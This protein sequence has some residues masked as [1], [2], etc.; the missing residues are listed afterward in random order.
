LSRG[1]VLKFDALNAKSV[2]DTDSLVTLKFS[3]PADFGRPGAILVDDKHDNEFFLKTI[4][5]EMPGTPV[6]FP[7]YSWISNSKLNGN[8]PRVFFSN[9]VSPYLQLNSLRP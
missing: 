5:V 9:Q 3:V 8:K 2:D 6:H 7:C 4:T 1:E